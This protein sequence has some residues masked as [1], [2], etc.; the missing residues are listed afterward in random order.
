MTE[1]MVV[2]NGYVRKVSSIAVV[3]ALFASALA[4]YLWLGVITPEAEERR[5]QNCQWF[6]G[7]H[8]ADVTA[9]VTQYDY[10]QRFTSAELRNNDFLS[11]FQ[12][13]P[14]AELEAARDRAPDYCDEPGVALPEPD[15]CVPLRPARIRHLA[16]VFG[17]PPQRPVQRQGDCTPVR[18]QLRQ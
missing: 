4:V 1:P 17:V 2:R 7:D 11:V 9:L 18:S 3:L 15:P 14:V 5:E 6:E 8:H 10:F 16:E 12:Q 13:L